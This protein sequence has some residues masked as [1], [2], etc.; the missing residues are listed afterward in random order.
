MIDGRSRLLLTMPND[1]PPTEVADANR[2]PVAPDA[3]PL[4]ITNAPVRVAGNSFVLMS[5]RAP[6][7]SP[8]R[9]GEN[10]FDAVIVCTSPAGNMSSGTTR[11]SGSGLGM[12]E[13]L[14]ELVV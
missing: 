9:S 11:F 1:S 6:L 3:Y 4:P 5:I 2:D 12:R 14:S 7:K 13:P 8:C 10:V